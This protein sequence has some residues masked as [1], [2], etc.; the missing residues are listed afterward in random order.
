MLSVPA[1]TAWILALIAL[2]LAVSILKTRHW[3]SVRAWAAARLRRPGAPVPAGG[4]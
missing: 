3:A 4:R 1:A 2:M